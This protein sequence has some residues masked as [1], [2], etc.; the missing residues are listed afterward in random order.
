MLG[1]RCENGGEREVSSYCLIALNNLAIINDVT[2]DIYMSGLGGIRLSVSR[3]E[4][5]I[6]N[7]ISQIREIDIVEFAT[8]LIIDLKEKENKE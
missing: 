2:I 7:T 3:G 4:R 6:T 1:G 5:C 8:R